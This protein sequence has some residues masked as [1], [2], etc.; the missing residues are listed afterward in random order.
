MPERPAAIDT[1][2]LDRPL[3]PIAVRRILLIAASFLLACCCWLMLDEGDS[4]NAQEKGA[5]ATAVHSAELTAAP[6]AEAAPRH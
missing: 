1:L 4:L 5:P 3:L 2:A 6:S